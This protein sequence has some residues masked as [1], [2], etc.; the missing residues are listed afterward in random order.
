MFLLLS[1]SHLF[2]HLKAAHL[3]PFGF[4][5]SQ[6]LNCRSKGKELKVGAEEGKWGWEIFK[7]VFPE[8][9]ALTGG[10]KDS[11]QIAHG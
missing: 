7:S 5:F 6:P 10:K 11:F 4:L 8:V 2:K 3:F 9:L 1:T